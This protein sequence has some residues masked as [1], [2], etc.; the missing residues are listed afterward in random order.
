MSMHAPFVIILIYTEISVQVCDSSVLSDSAATF[1][2]EGGGMDKA[3]KSN[4]SQLF[5]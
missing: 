2:D 5:V 4:G 3:G 1:D